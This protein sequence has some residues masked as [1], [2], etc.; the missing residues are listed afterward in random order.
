MSVPARLEPS[1]LSRSPTLHPHQQL[2]RTKLSGPQKLFL[3]VPLTNLIHALAHRSTVTPL[4]RSQLAHGDPTL[5]DSE[6]EAGW[7]QRRSPTSEGS[8]PK[9]AAATVVEALPPVRS[10]R[11]HKQSRK[12]RAA[13][14]CCHGREP[15]RLIFELGM[16]LVLSLAALGAW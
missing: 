3:N 14:L 1:G 2:V 11:R 15:Y 16:G 9:A 5:L 7:G 8:S 12:P 10:R 6:L 13:L 4:A